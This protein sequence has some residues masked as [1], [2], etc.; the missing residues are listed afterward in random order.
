VSNTQSQE[1]GAWE[2]YKSGVVRPMWRFY[3]TAPPWFLYPLLFVAGL[4]S[5]G[6]LWLTIPFFA[7]MR[8]RYPT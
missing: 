7:Y 2:A 1:H 3:M 4:A 5:G 6:I 8:H